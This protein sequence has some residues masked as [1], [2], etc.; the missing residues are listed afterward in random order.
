MAYTAPPSS[1]QPWLPALERARKRLMAGQPRLLESVLCRSERSVVNCLFERAFHVE[2]T[3]VGLPLPGRSR[4]T[5]D[6]Q[7]LSIHPKPVRLAPAPVASPTAD[8]LV[9]ASIPDE[10]WQHGLAVPA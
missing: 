1:E 7:V 2:R 8:M 6:V 4:K 9:Y 3:T 10:A 5:L